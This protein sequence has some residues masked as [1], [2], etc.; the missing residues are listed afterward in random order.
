MPINQEAIS[1]LLRSSEDYLKTFDP[2]V[3]E[4]SVIDSTKYSYSDMANLI[5]THNPSYSPVDYQGNPLNDDSFVYGYLMDSDHPERIQY[6]SLL[7]ENLFELKDPTDIRPPAS[8]EVY[9]YK[10]YLPSVLAAVPSFFAGSLSFSDKIKNAPMMFAEM[11]IKSLA[12]NI[13]NLDMGG[14]VNDYKNAFKKYGDK[15]DSGLPVQ[16]FGPMSTGGLAKASVGLLGYVTGGK[17]SGL[18]IIEE[19]FAKR[20]ENIFNKQMKDPKFRAYQNYVQYLDDPDTKFSDY[21]PANYLSYFHSAISSGITTIGT[22][23]AVGLAAGPAAGARAAM[24][25]AF[26]LEGTDQWRSSYEYYIDQGYSPLIASR[27]SH[28]NGLMYGMAAYQLERLPVFAFLDTPGKAAVKKRLYES[29]KTKSAKYMGEDFTNNTL[30][31]VVNSK[32]LGFLF[33]RSVQGAAESIQEGLQYTAE[34]AIELGYKGEDALKDF[35][36]NLEISMTKGGVGG[37]LLGL[38]GAGIS[39]AGERISRYREKGEQAVEKEVTGFPKEKPSERIDPNAP[40]SIIGS[41][42]D[43]ENVSKNLE[44]AITQAGDKAFSNPDALI[45]ALKKGGDDALKTLGI[46]PE[47]ALAQISDLFESR[48]DIVSKATN[49]LTAVPPAAPKKKRVKQP[50]T[51]TK[52]QMDILDKDMFATP[53]QVSEPVDTETA[54]PE[55]EIPAAD[56]ELFTGKKSE[57]MG[58]APVSNEGQLN[59]FHGTSKDK[60][61]VVEKESIN[62]NPQNTL[63]INTDQ[64]EVI[65]QLQENNVSGANKFTI[66]EKGKVEQGFRAVDK[67]IADYYKDKYEFIE[68]KNQNLPAKGSEYLRLKDNKF[69]TQTEEMASM[70]AKQVSRKEIAVK[71]AGVSQEDLKA[72]FQALSIGQMPKIK[73]EPILAEKII[74]SLKKRFPKIEGKEVE[75]IY[76]RVGEEQAGKA[77]GMIAEWSKGKATIDTAP[78]EYGHILIDALDRPV[79]NLKSSLIIEQAIDE[80]AG[81]AKTREDAK[82]KLVQ[83]MGEYYANNMKNQPKGFVDRFKTFLR[84]FWAQVKKSFGK[85]A[86]YVA[87]QFAEGG[88]FFKG[89]DE[90]AAKQQGEMQ[91]AKYQPLSPESPIFKEAVIMIDDAYKGMSVETGKKIPTAEF[92]NRMSEALPPKFYGALAAWKKALMSKMPN[93][94]MKTMEDAAKGKDSYFFTTTEEFDRAFATEAHEVVE[95][96]SGIDFNDKHIQAKH[97]ERINDMFIASLNVPITDSAFANLMNEAIGQDYQ[98]WTKTSFKE[99][100]KRSYKN[101]N[102]TQ[103][104]MVVRMYVQANSVI[105]I[106]LGTA[107]PKRRNL[108]YDYTNNKLYIKGPV[109]RLTGDKNNKRSNKY[110]YEA[111]GKDMKSQIIWLNSSDV[112]IQG[113]TDYSGKQVST[114]WSDRIDPMTAEDYKNLDRK[115]YNMSYEDDNIQGMVFLGVRGDSGGIMTAAITDDHVA[116][117]SDAKKLQAYWKALVDSE[118]ITKDQAWKLMGYTGRNGKATKNQSNIKWLAGEIARMESYGDLMPLSFTRNGSEFF[119]RVK[120]ATTPI[121]TSPMMQDFTVQV[122]DPENIIF[123]DDKGNEAKAM[124][125]VL[126]MKDLKNRADGASMTSKKFFNSLTQAFGTDGQI[127]LAK[128]VIWT[129]D[130]KLAVKHQQHLP[131]SNMEMYTVDSKGNRI[132][133]AKTDAEGNITLANGNEID[134]LMTTDEA[135]ILGHDLNKTITVEGNEFGLIKY[136]RKKDHSARFHIQWM[137]YAVS[138]NMNNIFKSNTIPK[139]K[140]WLDRMYLISD[141]KE[142]LPAMIHSM[143]K[144]LKNDS[145]FAVSNALVDKAELGLGHHPDAEPMLDRLIKS[146]IIDPAVGL[147]Y[148][149]G[150][151]LDVSPDWTGKMKEYD[152]SLADRDALPVRD[153]YAKAKNI[154]R[155]VA[156]QVPVEEINKWLADNPVEVVISR[157]PIPGVHGIFVGQVVELHNRNGQAILNTETGIARLEFDWDGDAIQV[158]FADQNM[159]DVIKAELSAAEQQGRTSAIDM[160]IYPSTA[161]QYQDLSNRD[162][163]YEL[164]SKFS[165]GSK[166]IGQVANAQSVYGQLLNIFNY[167]IVDNEIIRLS[168]LN[169]KRSFP[170]ANEADLTVEQ[171][172]RRWLQASVDN[173]KFL[174]LDDWNYTQERVFRSMF[175]RTDSKGRVLGAITDAQWNAMKGFVNKHKTPNYIKNGGTPREQYTLSSILEESAKYYQYVK[176]REQT[177]LSENSKTKYYDGGLDHTPAIGKMTAIKFKNKT[178]PIE[179]IAISIYEGYIDKQEKGKENPI[180]FKDNVYKN[181]HFDSL[182][183]LQANNDDNIDN[184]LKVDGFESYDQAKSSVNAGINYVNNMWNSYVKLITSFNNTIG[185]ISWDKNESLA[186]FADTWNEQ[187]KTLNETGKVVATIQFL[188]NTVN[189]DEGKVINQRNRKVLPPFSKNEDRTLLHPEIMQQYLKHYNDRILNVEGRVLNK[190]AFGNN[191]SFASIIR[192]LC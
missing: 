82:E 131:P 175:Y 52:D 75:V 86:E 92:I 177:I 184:A 83:Y 12:S 105:P 32:S 14:V 27:A 89:V 69:F 49:I 11:D 37:T 159:I 8:S 87:Q 166:A 94:K 48:P 77:F 90:V 57:V 101:L 24:T 62:I 192:D 122:Y 40:E 60:K 186:I 34:T 15:Y 19:V 45:S 174:L 110:L 66:N 61:P 56:T 150:A 160:S 130:L 18:D 23:A 149:K 26:V 44:E 129:K 31:N 104:R 143:L 73:D 114:T 7:Q 148:M 109:N 64:S 180:R 35:K 21:T 157:S 155:Q 41:V 50:V 156:K 178:A 141:S 120:I 10:Q 6:A 22:G 4:D 29:I 137:N 79:S 100:T 191:E 133:Y 13:F 70:Y 107:K 80:F 118:E 152:V 54:P 125:Y 59:V 88:E 93:L 115:L 161:G 124:Q 1:N 38:G 42:L 106:N 189:I 169:Q 28:S 65:K 163:I 16:G 185:P 68:Y 97:G 146:Q 39:K 95:G 171:I 81:D 103:K 30:K 135:K 145:P 182:N 164:A 78:H 36:R 142:T 158:E 72:N 127:G 9:A 172:Y 43:L 47:N 76:N 167:A 99:Y 126:G 132:L 187:Y 53:D 138:D 96:L 151:Y 139:L 3:G 170:E 181:V 117:A 183:D 98:D 128:S 5:K 71:E 112:Y 55:V 116:I 144:V 140:R 2:E 46:T 74:T 154:S 123:I 176:N 173:G 33:N 20:A 121:F 113:D 84:K 63:T 188:R 67:F 190:N 25:M 51:E 17:R 102:G 119:R 165:S 147:S 179:D 153:A 91:V 162:N 85:P 108:E 168:A 134:I 58:E 136:H 111:T